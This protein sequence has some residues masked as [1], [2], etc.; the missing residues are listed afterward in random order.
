MNK[1]GRRVPRAL[2]EALAA[3]SL[4]HSCPWSLEP[5]RAVVNIHMLSIHRSRLQAAFLDT[6]HLLHPLL[7]TFGKF[8]CSGPLPEPWGRNSNL[9][10]DLGAD[11]DLPQSV[12]APLNFPEDPFYTNY[13]VGISILTNFGSLT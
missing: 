11:K 2:E 8:P 9:A 10:D 6:K 7:T 5:S 13:L 1:L 12:R 3:V 4:L